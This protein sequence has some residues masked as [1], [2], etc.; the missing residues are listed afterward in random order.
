MSVGA[1][2][3]VPLRAYKRFVSPW[4]PPACRFHPTC[5]EYAA[6]AIE[7]YGAG[8]GTW[9][10]LLRLLRCNPLFPGGWDPPYEEP[11]AA[12]QG[13]WPPGAD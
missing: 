4:L 5:S 13:E 10:A 1:V 2:L 11:P 9:M 6:L 8:R 12:V 7:R 3:V